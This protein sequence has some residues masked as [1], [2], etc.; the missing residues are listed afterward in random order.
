[1]YKYYAIVEDNKIVEYPVNPY[2]TQ[3]LPDFWLGGELDGKQYVFCHTQEPSTTHL[4]VVTEAAP[5]YDEASGHWY[6]TFDVTT[7]PDELVA[8]RTAHAVVLAYNTIASEK[9]I[10]QTF[11][12]KPLSEDQKRDWAAYA[13]ALDG[14]PSYSGFPWNIVWPPR[15]DTKPLN[16]GVTRV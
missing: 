15:P 13:V 6:R 7:A 2:L 12:L 8:E 16:I 4:D 9:E 11:L 3:T 14:V 5:K 10:T 1:M